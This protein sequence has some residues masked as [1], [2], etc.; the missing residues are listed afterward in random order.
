MWI[1]IFNLIIFLQPP[2]LVYL[3]LP[4]HRI[5]NFTMS[6]FLIVFNPYIFDLSIS[7][8]FSVKLMAILDDI[9]VKW[10][11][12]LSHFILQF[13]PHYLNQMHENMETYVLMIKLY[14]EC[15]MTSIICVS[16]IL[17]LILG[18]FRRVKYQQNITKE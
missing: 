14:C 10:V 13:Y 17:W 9:C 2:L 4:V 7:L 11:T 6:A 16:Y 5:L 1:T 15:N 12:I 3:N 8:E 18:I